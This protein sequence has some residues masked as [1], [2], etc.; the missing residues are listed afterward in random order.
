[1]APLAATS[2]AGRAEWPGD[3]RQRPG[4]SGELRDAAV[5]LVLVVGAT[6]VVLGAHWFTDVL[7]GW[8]LGAA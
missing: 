2:R 7:A 4:A 5:V 6:R 3:Q 1:M 8:L